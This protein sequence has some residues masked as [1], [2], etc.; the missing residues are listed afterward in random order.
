M[1][2]DRNVPIYFE[3]ETKGKVLE[4]ISKLMPDDGMLFLGGAET[5]L[6]VSDRFKP[7]VPSQRGIYS[8][9]PA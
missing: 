4:S 9:V 1:A 8:V 5:V 7:V 3:Q 6:G 2:P